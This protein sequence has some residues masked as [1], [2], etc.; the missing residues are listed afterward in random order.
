[1]RRLLRERRPT[2]AV[3]FHTD[4]GWGG[5]TELRDAGYRLETLAGEPL[6]AGPGI[7]RVYQCVALPL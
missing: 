6:E 1:M 4:A 5:R 7:E 3:E 2:L